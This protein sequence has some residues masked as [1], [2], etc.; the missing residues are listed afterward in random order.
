[1]PSRRMQWVLQVTGPNIDQKRQHH[2]RAG[3]A[4]GA[5]A[6]FLGFGR[7]A[8]ARDC[9]LLRPHQYRRTAMSKYHVR[10]ISI[11]SNS[12]ANPGGNAW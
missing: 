3:F 10:R 9:G 1:M 2:R 12:L 6:D 11:T 5:F 4:A 7:A 8:S